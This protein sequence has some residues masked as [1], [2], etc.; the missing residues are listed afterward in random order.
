MREFD[1]RC[2]VTAGRQT[3]PAARASSIGSADPRVARGPHKANM[4]VAATTQ[5]LAMAV[6]VV[7]S[8]LS[9]SLRVLVGATQ[10][11]GVWARTQPGARRKVGAC[12]HKHCLAHDLNR[13]CLHQS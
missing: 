7:R 11:L 9:P 10:Q 6:A 13:S 8:A 5:A 12:T 4:T 3:H 2:A 1:V